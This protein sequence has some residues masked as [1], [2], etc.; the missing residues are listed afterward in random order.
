MIFNYVWGE[1]PNEN[2]FALVYSISDLKNR[3]EESPFT[4]DIHGILKCLYRRNFRSFIFYMD[5]NG[6]AQTD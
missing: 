2:H 1:V 3:I 4:E 6:T 5:L